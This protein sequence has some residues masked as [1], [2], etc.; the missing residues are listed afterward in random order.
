MSQQTKQER[1]PFHLSLSKQVAEQ[2]RRGTSSWL[3]S[4]ENDGKSMP[5]NPITGKIYTAVNNLL[6]SA[7]GYKD[8]RWLT[9]D[10]ASQEGYRVKKGEKS[11]EIVFYSFFENKK[12]ENG[13]EIKV[14]L[15]QP[16]VRTVKLFN[17][18]QLDGIEKMPDKT[19][20]KEQLL[21]KV[22][23]IFENSEVKIVNNQKDKMFYRTKEDTIYM[24]KKEAYK[25]ELHY[26]SAAIHELC[27]W[28]GHEDRM[29]SPSAP[30][31]T[32]AFAREKL[33]TEIATYMITKELGID[34]EPQGQIFTEQWANIIEKDPFEILNAAKDAEKIKDYIMQFENTLEKQLEQEQNIISEQKIQQETDLEEE[35]L[36]SADEP[37]KTFKDFGIAFYAN[38]G[39][40]N[41]RLLDE[42]KLKK[43][44]LNRLPESMDPTVADYFMENM[45]IKRMNNKTFEFLYKLNEFDPDF[46]KFEKLSDQAKDELD[47]V[48]QNLHFIMENISSELWE[49]A[50]ATLQQ[51]H[52]PS[53]NKQ[54]FPKEWKEMILLDIPYEDKEEAKALGAKW[55]KNKGSWY[56]LEGTNLEPFAKWTKEEQNQSIDTIAEK[57]TFL[58]VP[59]TEKEKAKKLGAKWDQD[60]KSWFVEPGT[61]LEQFSK[62]VIDE[63]TITP[64]KQ[65][66][67]SPEIEFTEHLR[68]MG[69]D[70]DHA[71]MDGQ[72]HRVPLIGKPQRKDGAYCG[73]LDGVPNGWTQNYV[74][75][76]KSKFI[77]SGVKLTA[78]EKAQQQAEL[79]QK[80]IEREEKR[81]Q[82]YDIAAQNAQKIFS[83][84]DETVNHPYIEKKGIQPYN[85][86]QNTFNQLVIPLQNIEGEIRGV[87]FINEDGT[88]QFLSGMEKK[89][90]FTFLNTEHKDFSKVL[91]CEG[92][93]TG[94]SLHE[95]TK[96]P[97][98]IAFDAGNLEPVAQAIYNKCKSEI[99]I[100][101]D[102]DQY[103]DINVGLEKA[104]EAAKA[105]N[106]KIC[107]PMFTS[108]EK[109][110]KLTDFNDLHQSQGLDAVRKQLGFAK[111]LT[112]T[113]AQQQ[114]KK[115]QLTR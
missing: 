49:M 26:G 107:V 59:Y 75:G 23:S 58:A 38:N 21:E 83:Q 61:N 42:K 12:N 111:S 2:I 65:E 19:P 98:A 97:V 82:D 13:E 112:Q 87:Q 6:L 8:N 40:P 114:T 106:G 64:R 43:E 7:Q 9:F 86:K 53:K 78:E 89:G 68:S 44:I 11:T 47:L 71:I 46:E 51:D 18:E 62:W 33:R 28:A 22:Q 5:Y 16:K 66:T 56:V 101:A 17:A 113:V 14:R 96:L 81:R 60:N 29:D 92:F 105:V 55:S 102:N 15:Q 20:N 76:E 37:K 48:D 95:A 80:K 30:F 108:K 50:N 32:E 77:A 73:F 54:E 52:Q 27:R 41:S 103:K 109:E 35:P 39:N 24:P 94:A 74:T 93:A 69:F 25:D 67:I 31:G 79:A 104:Q 72:I 57:K 85:A 45:K 110:Q 3:V 88:K 90:N 36:I 4:H 1:T 84:A 115:T 70:V 10:Q 34:Y 63:K 91:L 99:I 100:C